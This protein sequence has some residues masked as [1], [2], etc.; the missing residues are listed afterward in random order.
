MFKLWSMFVSGRD[1]RK[2]VIDSLRN[3]ICRLEE[4]N[5]GV[6]RKIAALRADNDSWNIAFSKL[7]SYQNG[8]IN[9]EKEGRLEEAIEQYEAS[10][11]FGHQSGMRVNNYYYSIERLTILYRK[12]RRYDDEIRIINDTLADDITEGDRKKL[13]SR[14]EKAVKLKEKI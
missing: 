2:Q 6:E 9:L 12:L 13:T 4:Y 10:V 3:D 7:M 11:N 8:G 5:R 1:K 14:L